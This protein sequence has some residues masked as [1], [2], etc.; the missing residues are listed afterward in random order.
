MRPLAALTIFA[1]LVP[2][3]DRYDEP[4][5]PQFHFSPDRNWPNDPCGLIYANREHHLFFQSNPFGDVW[6]HMSWGHA[7]SRDLVHWKQLTVAIPE[8]NGVMIYT[9]SS[10][11]D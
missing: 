6:G 11:L 9:G 4:F 3:A 7:I 10:V 1:A 5:R 2:G 8:G